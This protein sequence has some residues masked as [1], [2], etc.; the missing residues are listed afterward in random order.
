MFRA[1]IIAI[2]IFDGSQ[3]GSLT[4]KVTFPDEVSC[5]ATIDHDMPKIQAGF[6]QAGASLKLQGKCE[7]V[8]D[9]SI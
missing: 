2:S 6:D 8:G 1:I 4:S 9:N 3:A 5:Q 7:K